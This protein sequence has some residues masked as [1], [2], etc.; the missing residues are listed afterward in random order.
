MTEFKSNLER[1]RFYCDCI[2]TCP[3]YEEF[4]FY[5]LIAACLQRRFWTSSDAWPLFA[6]N[7]FIFVGLPGTGKT[8]AARGKLKVL[9]RIN[10][11]FVIKPWFAKTPNKGGHVTSELIHVA[12]DSLTVE[13]LIKRM[14]L[15][16]DGFKDQN[17]MLQFQSSVTFV[18]E[19]L[20]VLLRLNEP[21][22][23]DFLKAAFDCS[24]KFSRETI[25]RGTD[26]ITNPC[27]NLL[28]GTTPE[29][30]SQGMQYGIIN[31]GMLGRALFIH[32]GAPTRK[33]ALFKPSPEQ[34][35][36]LEY[37]Y[38]HCRALCGNEG[39][40][41]PLSHEA[42][43]FFEDWHANK[44]IP[45]NHDP[46]LIHYYARKKIQVLKLALIIHFSESTTSREIQIS[47]IK[48]ALEALER[49]EVN[50]HLALSSAGKNPLHKLAG[51]IYDF[52][53]RSRKPQT[54]DFLSVMFHR[55]ADCDEVEKALKHLSQAKKLTFYMDSQLQLWC[56]K[57]N[58]DYKETQ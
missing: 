5:S 14:S 42:E 35:K 28:A 29:W 47:D 22:I 11:S 10:A 7:Y 23:I 16:M 49:V 4:S 21:N 1:Y 53:K 24:D 50:M 52:F 20:G 8:N 41:I 57:L 6:N 17:G 9:N 26:T 51:D 12:P 58:P 40:F 37:V 54:S 32:G 48:Q 13:Q 2:E 44:N 55:Q 27:V 46:T 33:R 18:S 15:E 19:E 38:Q 45:I 36:A 25:G 56:Y 34:D 30:I 43:A 31:D 39:S 3:L